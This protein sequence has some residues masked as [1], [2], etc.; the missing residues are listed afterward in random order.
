MVCCSI[1]GEKKMDNDRENHLLRQLKCMWMFSRERSGLSEGWINWLHMLTFYHH[2]NTDTFIVLLDYRNSSCN[3]YLLLQ[4]H[5]SRFHHNDRWPLYNT[6]YACQIPQTLS[7]THTSGLWTLKE[8][9]LPHVSSCADRLIVQDLRSWRKER[10]K[11]LIT[12]HN[13][14]RQS[15]FSISAVWY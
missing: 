5:L 7:H 4:A 1:N 14:A 15:I 10:N 2:I 3:L 8:F 12:L 6:S 11:H 9:N 13:T